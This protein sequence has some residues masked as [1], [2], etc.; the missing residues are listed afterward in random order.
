VLIEFTVRNFRS[1]CGEQKF[2]FSTSSDRLLSSSH[3]IRTGLKSVPR[4]S[5]SAVIFGP[6][7]SGKSNLLSAL[8]V[9]RDLVLHSTT[10]SD[11]DYAERYSPFLLDKSAGRPT[12]F[13]VDV[14]LDSVRYQYAFAYDEHRIRF[15]RLLVYP[16]GKSQRWFERSSLN[17]FGMETWAPFS[18]NFTGPRA[19]W[20][21]ATRSQALFLTTAAQ[22]NARQLK[23]LFDWF[24]GGLSPVFASTKIDVSQIAKYIQ[25]EKRKSVMLQ[26]LHCA[27]F[28]VQDVRLSEPKS[29][30]ASADRWRGPGKPNRNASDQTIIEFSHLRDDGSVV[31]MQSTDESTGVQRLVGLFG[32]LLTALQQG[33]LLLVDEFDL[34]LHPLVARYLIQLFNNPNISQHGAQMLLTSHNT[35]LMDMDILRRDEIWLMELDGKAASTLLR[36][37]RSA[38]PPRKNELIGKRYLY[39]RYG[40][41]PEIQPPD[42]IV[43]SLQTAMPPASGKRQLA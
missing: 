2:S 30:G 43:Q 17:D 7:G 22:L 1:I 28:D 14:L 42:L 16:T 25:D 27:G 18:T 23:P 39:G 9:M 31:W 40:A 36:M 5:K 3:C 13:E 11:G 35:T 12:E 38:S 20:R 10:F 21:D 8:S 19:M 15:E 33:Q 26:F 41:V 6:N 37:W 29:A 24:A 32:P 34:S 4:V